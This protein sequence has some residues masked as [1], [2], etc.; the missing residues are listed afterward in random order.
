MPIG[1]GRHFLNNANAVANA[2]VG[3]W[4]LQ[5]IQ[6]WSSGL[7]YTILA[8]VGES[9]TDG[10]AEERPN[11]VQGVPLYPAN[12][13]ANSW[14][15]PAAFTATAFGSYGNSGRNIIYTAPQ[16]NFDTSLFKDFPLHE[17]AKL[18]FRGE[19]FNMF[20]HT[21]FRANSLINQFDAPGAGSYTAAQP[22]RQIQFALKLIF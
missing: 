5:G 19:V 13:G 21:N 22:A 1:K 10:D 3:G 16:V 14:F 15:N 2:F 7:P 18:Q 9:N 17:R 11:R 12:Q 4:E 8:S 20:N 6:S